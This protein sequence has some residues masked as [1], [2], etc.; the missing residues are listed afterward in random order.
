MTSSYNSNCRHAPIEAE[1]ELRRRP[2]RS[3]LS[4]QRCE[5]VV[6]GARCERRTIG[7]RVKVLEQRDGALQVA[8]GAA[9]KHAQ[10][11]VNVGL[12]GESHTCK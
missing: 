8:V 1:L 10:H 11:E 9:E 7:P 3:Q 4:V 5:R 6:G 2:M 12:V